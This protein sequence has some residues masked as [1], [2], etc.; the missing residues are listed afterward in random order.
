MN[1]SI[2]NEQNPIKKK[3]LKSNF[4]FNFI[5]QILALI[6]PLATSPYLARVLGVEI[7]GQI[8]FSTSIITYFTLASN[9]GFTTYGQ[10][11]IAKW[12]DDKEKRSEV[13]WE[14]FLIRTLFTIVSLGVLLGIIFANVFDEKYKTFLLIQT[15]TVFACCVDPS[16][17][18]QGMEEFKLIAIRTIVVRVIGLILIFSFVKT[19]D[20][21]WIYV[22]F[23]SGATL[24][25]NLAMW[26]LIFKQ[27]KMV[28]IKNLRIWRHFVPALLI[29]LP[30]LAVTIYSVLDK[31][32]IGLIAVNPDYENG[33]YEK[34]YQLNSIMLLVVTLVSSVMIPRNAHDYAVGDTKSLNEHI[35]FSFDY[36]WLTGL[37]LIIGCSVLCYS[38]SSWFLGDGYEEVPILLQIMSVRFIAAGIGVVVGDQ[39]FIAIGKEK[40]CTIATSI[41][42][43]FNF[44][45]NFIFIKFWGA[46]GAAITT[47]CTEVLVATINICIALKKK[48]ISF[49]AFISG[50]P[51][52]LIASVIMFIPLF[53]LNRVFEYGVWSFLLIMLVGIITYAL[54]LIVLKDEFFLSL[55]KRGIDMLKNLFKKKEETK[56][57]N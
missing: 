37:P 2:V 54:S 17:Y 3:S 31:T 27:T 13:Y 39:L 53:F 18:Y 5:S 46:T 15:I 9:F 49:N 7:T 24:L 36:T 35:K 40:Y 29:F 25:S 43:V 11:E 4:I 1:S 14:I 34:A 41:G 19:K 55:L 16:F 26:P 6:I 42:A 23:N 22:L 56:I 30:N 38:L 48:Y 52:K 33:C 50:M 10:R 8:S 44:S 20:D 28:K 45:L 57:E 51:K 47:A 32:M 21:A 12:Q